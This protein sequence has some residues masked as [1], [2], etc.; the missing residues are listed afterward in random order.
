M[1]LRVVL[2]VAIAGSAAACHRDAGSPAPV[3]AKPKAGIQKAAPAP[4]GP[5]PQQLTADMVEAVAQGKAQGPF[6]LKFDLLERPVPG[7]P[8]EI[9]LALLPQTAAGS[10]TV[11]VT[12]AEGLDLQPGEEHFEFAAIEAARVYRHSIKVTPASEGLYV[13]TLSVSL[14]HEQTSDSRVFSV[15]ILVGGAG[16]APSHGGPAAN[17]A[18]PPADA[19]KRGS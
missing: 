4:Q 5:N 6:D 1:K 8:L 12:G 16:G 9:A 19:A 2:L 14:Q 7:K 17:A 10:A 11:A 15:P 3:A 18:P 13:L